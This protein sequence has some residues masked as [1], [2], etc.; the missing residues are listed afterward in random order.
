MKNLFITLL[1][2][3]AFSFG[4]TAQSTAYIKFA[5]DNYMMDKIVKTSDNSYIGVASSAY[6]TSLIKFNAQFQVMWYKRIDGRQIVSVPDLQETAIGNFAFLGVWGDTTFLFKFSKQGALM[7]C[8]YFTGT[9]NNFNPTSMTRAISGDGL[10]LG[11][12]FC[13]TDNYIIRL[14]DNLNVLWNYKY[15]DGTATCAQS[16]CSDIVTESNRYVYTFNP[17]GGG[18]NLISIDDNGAVLNTRHYPLNLQLTGYPLEFIKLENGGYVAT[19]ESVNWQNG[20][21]FVFFDSSLSS[22]IC[23]NYNLGGTYF[24]N[25]LVEYDHNRVMIAGQTTLPGSGSSDGSNLFFSVNEKGSIVWAK[26]SEG[27]V[28][29]QYPDVIHALVKGI[30]KSVFAFGGGSEPLNAA[31]LDYGGNGYCNSAPLAATIK[32]ADTASSVSR[33]VTKYVSTNLISGSFAAFTTKDST[34]SYTTV[35]G[36]LSNSAVSVPTTA[37]G[38]DVTTFPIPCHNRLNLTGLEDGATSFIICD[39]SGRVVVRGDVLPAGGKAGID[40]PALV[41]GQYFGAMS[42]QAGT[43]RFSFTK[44]D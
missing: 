41:S 17:S 3:L 29:P 28:A 1:S 2:V 30:G 42:N 38:A 15:N 12:G 39:V 21:E 4:A 26:T 7:G 6:G 34:C 8:K 37:V 14:D 9:L 44:V 13:N 33:N 11:G 5:S 22:A 19:W 40:I 16:R 32:T 43:R 18:I 25:N 36:K 10:V 20:K 27:S 35:C 23:R 31:Q 24:L